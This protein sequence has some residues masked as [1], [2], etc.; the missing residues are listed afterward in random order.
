MATIGG[1]LFGYDQGVVGNVLV[2]ESF[3]Y[4]FPRFY[5]DETVK[6]IMMS[7]HYEIKA[8]EYRDGLSQAYC[9]APGSAPLLVD[10]LSTD[11]VGSEV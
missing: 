4:E 2:L 10:R 7:P 1:F 9:W 3:G 11:L 6:V 5:A 8:D